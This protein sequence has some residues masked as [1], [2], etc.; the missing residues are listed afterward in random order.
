MDVRTKSSITIEKEFTNQEDSKINDAL[1]YNI[2]KKIELKMAMEN[3][4]EEERI[5]I[6]KKMPANLGKYLYSPLSLGYF[7]TVMLGMT[8]LRYKG[9]SYYI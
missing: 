9:T 4:Y 1:I 5:P 7:V 8:Y 3:K 6:V 2:I